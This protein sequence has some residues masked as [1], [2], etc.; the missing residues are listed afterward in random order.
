MTD[1]IL[2]RRAVRRA[3]ALAVCASLALPPLADPA[4]AAQTIL[5]D[6]PIV[7]RVAAKPNIV[8]TLDD[9]GSMALNYIPLYVA[10][11]NYP[12]YCRGGIN[13]NASGAPYY[14]L[15]GA[16]NNTTVL[17]GAGSLNAFN[18]PP[19]YGADFNRMAYNPRAKYLPPLK[20]DGTPLTAAVTD[21]QG[22]QIN[23]AKVQSDPYLSAATTVDLTT[24]VAVP[25]YC[26]TDWPLVGPTPYNGTSNVAA[27]VIGDI[28]DAAGEN[29]TLNPA[30][31]QD[32][33]INGTPYAAAA[34]SGAPAIKD[35]YNYPWPKVGAT[36][37]TAGVPNAAGYMWR[38]STVRQLWCDKTN[39]NWPQT[40]SG[41]WK[42]SKGG[43]VIWPPTVPQ[44]CYWNND[45]I[46]CI[47]PTVYSPAG[48]NT[49]PAYDLGGCVGPE[50]LKCT[51]LGC[52]TG[53]T[54]EQGYCHTNAGPPPSGGSGAGCS[55]AG[56]GCTLPACPAYQPPPTGCTKGVLSHSCT[57]N[58]GACT[59]F[60][61]DPIN[62]V[63]LSYT[64]L[65]DSNMQNGGTG[66]ICRHNNFD[67][68]TQTF[69]HQPAN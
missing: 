18:Y 28:G 46:G 58:A 1:S 39:A 24:T 43:T 30:I 44:T 42:C 10:T 25:V 35:D 16:Y 21:A 66:M 17:C 47:G 45:I 13:V 63:N 61:F 51:N 8:Y 49:N 50:C 52:P 5:A 31:G 37:G 40:C 19:F 59:D 3:L 27:F 48:C 69:V 64:L 11:G 32:C 67:Y 14:S 60:A 68:S 15:A 29:P 53:V 62:S 54:G 33:R 38:S 6:Q 22:N 9:S 20:A 2:K 41:A 57:P 26:H 65:Q 23:L 36:A 4:F 55:C 12:W 7:A 34:G 56:A